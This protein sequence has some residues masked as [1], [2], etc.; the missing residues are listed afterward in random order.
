MM[1]GNALNLFFQFSNTVKKSTVVPE[2]T[3]SER[4]MPGNFSLFNLMVYNYYI[5]FL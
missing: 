5:K 4:E 2:K 1:F 3:V